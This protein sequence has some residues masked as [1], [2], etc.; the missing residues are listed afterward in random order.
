MYALT[1]DEECRQQ[2]ED[3]AGAG[4]RTQHDAALVVNRGRRLEK[5]ADCG[6]GHSSRA[7]SRTA[8][9]T[10]VL[11]HCALTDSHSATDYLASPRR[12]SVPADEWTA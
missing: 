2:E 8:S 1:C 9:A 4:C 6:V 11:V 10:A 3:A 5:R 7:R 12:S